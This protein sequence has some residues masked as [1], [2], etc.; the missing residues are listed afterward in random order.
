MQVEKA[1]L[2]ISAVLIFVGVGIY[3]YIQQV[4]KKTVD[5]ITESMK[6]VD[7]KI[8]KFSLLPPNADIAL[9][10]QIT[11][12]TRK[13]LKLSINAYLYADRTLATTFY[14]DKIN[15]PARSNIKIEIP[16]K[17][18]NNKIDNSETLES[19]I[20]VNGLVKVEGR[21]IFYT[22]SRSKILDHKSFGIIKEHIKNLL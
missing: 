13:K 1:L 5:K 16:L 9:I 19:E 17:L 4:L 6:L 22:A 8:K 10:S 7:T 3:I 21:V 12:P 18:N 15:L 14:V 20:F 11:N 2:I